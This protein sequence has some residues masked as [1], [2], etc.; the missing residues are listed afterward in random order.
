MH[1]ARSK[2]SEISS[3]VLLISIHF[4]R[5]WCVSVRVIKL[6]PQDSK[7]ASRLRTRITLT[8]VR[9]EVKS[10]VH[11]LVLVPCVGKTQAVCVIPD[12]S[13]NEVLPYRG[14]CF[15]QQLQCCRNWRAATFKHKREACS[16]TQVVSPFYTSIP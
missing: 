16:K 13:S 9:S 2:R 15:A 1:S 8:H 14:V 3:T 12:L 11:T 6:L 4:E 5:A 7:H 10:S